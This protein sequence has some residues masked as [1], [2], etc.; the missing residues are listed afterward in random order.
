MASRTLLEEYLIANAPDLADYTPGV[1]PVARELSSRIECC[2][3]IYL[4]NFAEPAPGN[5]GEFQAVMIMLQAWGS[6]MKET[7]NGS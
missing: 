5:P 3:R 6:I 1:E 4:E 2:R 7:P